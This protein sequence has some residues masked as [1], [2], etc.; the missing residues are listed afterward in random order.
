MKKDHFY[1]SLQCCALLMLTH[2]IE[3]D[4]ASTKTQVLPSARLSGHVP[5]KA[6]SKAVYLK[7]LDPETQVPLTF[8]LPLRNREALEKLV[9]SIY[10]PADEQHY[11]RYLTS[12]E[13]ASQFGPAQKDYDR[14]IAWAKRAGLSVTGTHPNRT[15]LNVSGSAAAVEK[16]F[17]VGLH[18]YQNPDGR[19]FYAPD[20]DPEVSGSI[21]S[22]VYG[23]VGLDSH[24]VRH[25]YHRRK[26]STTLSPD[27]KSP[28]HAFPSGP[29]GGYAPGDLLT[30]YNLT[31]VKAN[32]SGQ[33]IALFELGGYLAS[34]ISTYT[35]QFGLPPARLKNV[36]VD[37]GSSG[38]PNPEVTLDI[39]LAL[40]LA[41]Q[42]EIYVYEGPNSEQGVLDTYNRIAT[43]NLAKQVSTSWGMGENESSA[44]SLQAEEA[45]FLQ[46]ASQGQTIYA[47]AGDSGAYDDYP[48][49]TLMVDDPASQP[50]VTG[51][52]GT[53]LTVNAQSGVYGSETVWND[54]PGQGAGGGGI[55]TVWPI[56]SWQANLHSASSMMFR[57]VPDVAL[58]ADP[59]TGY[60][61]YYNGQWTIYG[62]TSCAAPLWAA[63]T[64]CV[65]QE[66]A[67]NQQP[68]LGFAN[69]LLYKI[70][71][72][73]SYTAD[74]HDI[75]S[76]N[77]QHYNA[78][79]GYDNASGWGTFNGASLFSSLTN[80]SP[81]PTSTVLGVQM[82][83]AGSFTRGQTGTWRIIVSNAGSDP[84]SGTV[85]AVMTL[86]QGLQYTSLAGSGW[87]FDFNNQGNLVC[88]QNSSLGAGSSYPTIVV[89]AEVGQNAPSS[90]TPSVTVS[91][92]GA[93]TSVTATNPT[94]VK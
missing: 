78:G 63:F 16:A 57:N 81:Q 34:D 55:S 3:V 10:D 31:S 94:T 66:L 67:A 50:Y 46:M 44:Q 53:S 86:P 17:N 1:R 69:P 90:V 11:H 54:G 22:I 79:M 37:G 64:A 75:V 14:V 26:E 84:T 2:V 52:G 39:E 68:A 71:L 56:P 65:N 15:L 12:E 89:T 43:D 48:S 8:M 28:S 72:G 33:T 7:K 70:G 58:N 51:V 92:G 20:N 83:H 61:I 77:N 9:Q 41:P 32:G 24:A 73:S 88:T 80:S 93:A 60:A 76:G 38:G 62:G 47:A 13:F 27:R 59:E 42:S 35:S 87:M 19:I 74:F 40:A 36:A 30:A 4:A 18:H 5:A 29:N 49:M 25:T 21:A 82:K 23:I 85:T 91:G 45:I 6:L